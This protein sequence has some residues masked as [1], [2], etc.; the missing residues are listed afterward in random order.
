MPNVVITPHVAWLSPESREASLR[1]V[2]GNLDAFFAGQPLLTPL[3]GA[4]R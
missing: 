3:G 4:G 1:L 2:R